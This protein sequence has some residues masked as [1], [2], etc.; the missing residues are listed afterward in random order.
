VRSDLEITAFADRLADMFSAY[1][2]TLN[3]PST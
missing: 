3:Q 1:V 2:M